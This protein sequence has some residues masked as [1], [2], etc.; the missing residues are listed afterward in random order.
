[1]GDHNGEADSY[2]LWSGTLL[3]RGSMLDDALATFCCWIH[4]VADYRFF[5]HRK[6]DVD[7]SPG[8]LSHLSRASAA[9]VYCGDTVRECVAYR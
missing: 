1:M 4:G 6:R 9:L 7:R 2:R 8:I 3:N 5:V